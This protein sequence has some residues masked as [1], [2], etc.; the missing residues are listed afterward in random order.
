METAWFLILKHICMGKTLNVITTSPPNRPVNS[1]L[2]QDLPTM[3]FILV[4]ESLSPMIVAL[5]DILVR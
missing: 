1:N 4:G 2:V 5:C 3:T